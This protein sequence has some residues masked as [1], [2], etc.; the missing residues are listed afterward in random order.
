MTI[1]NQYALVPNGPL[2]SLPENSFKKEHGG[3]TSPSFS[4]LPPFAQIHRFCCV[5]LN[6]AVPLSR[7]SW[8]RDFFFLFIFIYLLGSNA[9]S[10][11]TQTGQLGKQTPGLFW[12]WPK[13]PSQPPPPPGKQKKREFSRP[14][15][16]KK[17]K[18][19]TDLICQKCPLLSLLLCTVKIISFLRNDMF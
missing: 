4:S 9:S 15:S 16:T 10:S 14:L 5:Y 1:D 17:Y 3:V 8:I 18:H 13:S 12:T 2:I 11:S 7:W 6:E 19:A